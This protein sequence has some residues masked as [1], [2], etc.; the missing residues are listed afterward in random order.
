MVEETG[1]SADH[2]TGPSMLL[3]RLECSSFVD[4]LTGITA[5]LIY[6]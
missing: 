4:R 3:Y 2:R 6:S 5:L 1:R